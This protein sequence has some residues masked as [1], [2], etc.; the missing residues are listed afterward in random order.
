MS[1]SLTIAILGGLGGM[2]GW[3]LADFLAKKTID[4]VGEVATLFWAQL[5]GLAPLLGILAATRTIP[6]LHTY[7]PLWLL[8]L[9]VVSALSYLS[10]YAGF[11]KGDLS[12]LSPVFSAHAALVVVISS[13]L[14]GEKI[15]NGQWVAI[16]VVLLGVIAI[17]TTLDGLLTALRGS[18]SALMRGLPNVVSAAVAFAFW[19]VLLDRF[20]GVRDWVFFLV[21]IR[22]TAAATVAVYARAT[23]ESLRLPV[24]Q[25]DLPAYVAS[26]GLCDAAAFAAVTYAFSA[27]THTSIVAVLS[28][29]FSL[30]TL[31]LARVFLRERLAPTQKIAA[32]VIIV[33][34]ALVSV[35]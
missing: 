29:T 28:S 6:T 20:I 17:S 21:V 7:D 5:I 14:F 19:L 3:G 25:S 9:G 2:A 32:G 22:A 24:E 8:L 30:P 1:S 18:R 23:G 10:L 12:F 27:T 33:G 15:S 13:V 31:V 4:R 16:V 34:I 26:I 11:G 35:Y